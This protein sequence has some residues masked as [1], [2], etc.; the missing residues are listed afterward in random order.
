MNKILVRIGLTVSLFISVQLASHAQTS[1][2]SP[3]P[4]GSWFIG[5]VVLPGG[6]KKWGGFAEVQFRSNALFQ[7][8]FYNELK[9]GVTYDINKNFTAAIAGGRYATYDYK[10]LSDGP[11]NIEGRL[12]EQF[13]INQYLSRLR[14]EHR[15]RVEQ[16]WFSFRDGTHPYRNRI[17]YRLNMFIPLNNSS[18][19]EKTYF[20]SIFD[21]IFLNPIGP[22][23]ERNRLFAG[24][25]YQMNKHVTVQLGWVNQ[26][27]YSP[28][29]FDQG[30]F[31]PIAHSGKN[32]VFISLNYRLNSVASEK[33]PS[34]VD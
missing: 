16:R 25:G 31:K 29:T 9:G 2:T 8:V 3:A 17:R 26:T 6:E 32:N 34:Q 13:T 18:L 30:I 15:Y 28:A 4:W 7:Q 12:W 22:T 24:L 1:L 23:F 5:T 19:K 33:L 21:E 11:L 14:F 20:I 27:N 10:E